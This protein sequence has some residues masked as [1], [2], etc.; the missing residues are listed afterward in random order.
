MYHLTHTS[1]QTF[2]IEPQLM[3]S[4]LLRAGKELQGD[5]L[6]VS[7]AEKF[8]SQQLDFGTIKGQG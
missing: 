1:L 2:H 8:F 5:W 7:Y 6:K 3:D 4:A